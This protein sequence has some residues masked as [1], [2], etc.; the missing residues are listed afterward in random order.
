MPAGMQLMKCAAA[1]E[2][3]GCWGNMAMASYMSIAN[4]FGFWCSLLSAVASD[5]LEDNLQSILRK[6]SF[7]LKMRTGFYEVDKCE[8]RFVE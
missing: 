7:H 6:F 1:S 8:R 2:F 3:V 5:G 4:E